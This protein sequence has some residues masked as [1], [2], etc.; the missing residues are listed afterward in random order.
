VSSESS[1]WIQRKRERERN[2]NFGD[3]DITLDY[4]R[5]ADFT[6]RGMLLSDDYTSF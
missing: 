4:A 2:E 1:F 5:R 3:D 6:A